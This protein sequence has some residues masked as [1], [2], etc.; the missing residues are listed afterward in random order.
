MLTSS[1]VSFPYS[2]AMSVMQLK[3]RL[4]ANAGVTIVLVIIMAK[5]KIIATTV[6]EVWIGFTIITSYDV[7]W[8]MLKGM[9]D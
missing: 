5:A 4:I 8:Q 9:A 2:L 6:S 7:G 1:I 3:N